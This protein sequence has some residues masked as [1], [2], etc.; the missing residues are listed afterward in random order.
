[1]NAVHGQI[2]GEQFFAAGKPELCVFPTLRQK[3]S[4]ARERWIGRHELLEIG[5]ARVAQR[6]FDVRCDALAQRTW[7]PMK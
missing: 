6:K 4:V 1:M 3:E 7:V 5:L 2:G